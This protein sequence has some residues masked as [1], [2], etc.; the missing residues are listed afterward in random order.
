MMKAWRSHAYG[1]EGN[2]ADAIEKLVCE[3]VPIPTAGAGQIQVKVS[4]AAVNPID[5]KLFSGGL[6]GIAPCAHPYI[7][8]FDIAGTVS[9]VGE[10]KDSLES[11]LSVLAA[12]VEP[13]T[14][15]KNRTQSSCEERRMRIGHTLRFCSCCA[16]P[17]RD[18]M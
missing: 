11:N 10:G 12:H 18:N 1:A 14:N 8:G 4:H 5:W 7:P 3:D 15:K 17:R 13:C 6:H 9:A 16:R 2:P